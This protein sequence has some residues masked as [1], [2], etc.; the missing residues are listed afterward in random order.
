MHCQK[1]KKC[2][3]PEHTFSEDLK[4]SN[5]RLDTTP[6][7]RGVTT[8]RDVPVPCAFPQKIKLLSIKGTTKTRSRKNRSF[9][10]IG[11]LCPH[12]TSASEHTSV[13]IFAK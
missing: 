6:W 1:N 12:W 10:T 9:Y 13:L 3:Y 4:C 5:H 7:N 8:D 11:Q 2:L